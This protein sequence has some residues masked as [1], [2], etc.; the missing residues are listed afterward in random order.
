MGTIEAQFTSFTLKKESNTRVM[1]M[2]YIQDLKI[3]YVLSQDSRLELF[4]I[5]FDNKKSLLSKIV[6]SEKRKLLKR[7]GLEEDKQ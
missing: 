5:N 2:H 1:E 7:K 3:I 6:R 4:K